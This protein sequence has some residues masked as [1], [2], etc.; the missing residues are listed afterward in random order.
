MPGMSITPASDHPVRIVIIGGGYGGA[1]CAQA[2]AKA[3]RRR[4]A[5]ATSA[6]LW[7]LDRHNYFI[8]Y[9]LLVEAGTGSLEPRHAVVPIRDFLP[10]RGPA[11]F[12]MAEVLSADVRTRTVTYSIVGERGRE[13]IEYDHLVLALGSVTRLPDESAVPGVRAHAFEMKSMADA[14]GLRDRAIEM[15]ER[16]DAARRDEHRRALLH[17]VVV[18]GNFSGVEV[19][20]EFDEFLKR[21]TKRYPHLEPGDCRVTLVEMADRILRPLGDD[22]S[23]FALAH[24]RRRGLDVRLETTVSR[25]EPTSV[26][27][28][29]GDT[30]AASTVIWCAGIEPGPLV[31][32]IDVPVDER[33]Y[34]LCERDLRVRGFENVWAIGDAAVN[35]DAGG[36]AYPATAQHAVQQGRHLARNLLATLD[37]RAVTPCD[38]ADRGQL[39]AIGCRTGVARVFGLKL[40][41]FWAWWLWRTVYLL[42]MPRL[43]RKVRVTL[44]WTVG[45]FF[46]RDDVQLGVHRRDP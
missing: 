46:R 39:A 33:G 21:A 42:K 25:V 5:S 2:L 27:L 43:G 1:Y 20:G 26:T 3:L 24:L 36:R 38:L 6:E 7:L 34:V 35:I 16:A 4:P 37:G 29:T 32:D 9:P 31:R 44:D 10:R 11:E 13:T 23:D 41:G 15:L 19:A 18:G 28:S 12:R 8:F 30:L 40:A 14:V 17:F 22:L 45:L